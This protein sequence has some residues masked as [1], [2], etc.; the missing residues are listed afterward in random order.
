MSKYFSRRDFLKLGGLS[1]GSL[2]FSRFTP[3]IF[4]PDFINFDDGDLVRVGTSRGVAVYSKPTDQNEVAG[5]L[6]ESR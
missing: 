1:L 5:G 6:L 2:A 3:N 4:T